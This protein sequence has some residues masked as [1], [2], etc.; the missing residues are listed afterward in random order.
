M[1]LHRIEIKEQIDTPYVSLDPDTG[2]CQISGKSYPE[3]IYEFYTQIIDWFEDFVLHGKKDLE[4][5][6]KLRY[7]NSSSQ[8]I[9][10]VI[11]EKLSEGT[12]F[13]TTVNWYY[14]KEDEEILENGKIFEGL[15]GLKFN[16]IP[17]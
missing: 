17:Y 3:D 8:K 4:I 6:M 11:F 13:K 7:F 15:T 10:N 16:Y 12:N 1:I 5:N 9:Y 2:I 14:D